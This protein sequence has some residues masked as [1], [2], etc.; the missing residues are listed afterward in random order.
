L[1]QIFD[2]FRNNNINPILK[3]EKSGSGQRT[4]P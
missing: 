4:M 1:L 3:V 2:L